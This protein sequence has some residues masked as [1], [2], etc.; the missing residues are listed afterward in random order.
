[1]T[2]T[3]PRRADDRGQA[4]T[5]EGFIASVVVLSAVLFALQALVFT[6]TSAGQVDE[7]VRDKLRT[8]A[9]D[10]LTASANNGTDDLSHHLRY[11][12]NVSAQGTWVGNSSSLQQGYGEDRPLSPKESVLG[13]GLNQ[14]FNQ[15]GFSYNVQLE[16]L[17]ATE[18]NETEQTP[19]VFRGV[20]TEE[21]VS[22]TY[23]VVLYDNETL[24]VPDSASDCSNASIEGLSSTTGDANWNDTN[25]DPSAKC[26]YP[27]PEAELFDDDSNDGSAAPGSSTPCNPSDSGDPECEY[28]EVDDSPIYN[29]VEVRV[30]IW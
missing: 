6:P 4:F 27:I 5:L 30:V 14:T 13:N 29:I 20:P 23:T 24:T 8:E 21:A 2:G 28:A 25:D 7:Q 18:A 19:M 22:V 12:N 17:S 11:F 16:Y 26:F 9:R 15:R 3:N 10:I 1:M